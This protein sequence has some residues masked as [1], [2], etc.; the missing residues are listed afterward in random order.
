MAET[1]EGSLLLEMFDND[2]LAFLLSAVDAKGLGRLACTARRFSTKAFSAPEPHGEQW[3]LIEEVARIR[4]NSYPDAVRQLV[5][6][7][8]EGE[9]WLR[10]AASLAPMAVPL[11]FNLPLAEDRT[12]LTMRHFGDY[13]TVQATCEQPAASGVGRQYVEFTA[14][15]L[16][17]VPLYPTWMDRA[18]DDYPYSLETEITVGLQSIGEDR[19]YCSWMFHLQ[20]WAASEYGMQFGTQSGVLQHTPPKT[21]IWANH[22]VLHGDNGWR[23]D[24]NHPVGYR[25]SKYTKSFGKRYWA[26][27]YQ[28]AWPSL[29]KGDR[30][31]LLWDAD[32]GNLAVFVNGVRAGF[33]NGRRWMGE[34]KGDLRWTASITTELDYSDSQ[35]A[36]KE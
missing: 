36:E 27:D 12:T 13:N 8:Q 34:I 3:S 28:D 6:P 23:P 11:L 15:Q 17:T 1:Q 7:R 18:Q 19:E 22:G 33:A 30:V 35:A 5:A 14:V 32:T 26:E 25:E 2:R 9:A 20:G 10:V 31:G 21:S 4:V 29:T 16:P 24:N